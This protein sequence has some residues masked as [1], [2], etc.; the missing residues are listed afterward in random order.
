MNKFLA[1]LLLI[2]VILNLQAQVVRDKD[3]QGLV[4]AERAF[5]RYAKEKNTRDAFIAFLADD[6]VTAAQGQGP[7]VGKKYLEDQKPNE[8]YLHWELAFSDIASSG[9]FGFNTGPWEF[10]EKKTDEKAVA[11]GQFVSAWKKD[12]DG[13]WKVIIDI[14]ITHEEPKTPT[15]WTAS[16]VK[17]K[18]S[19]K[20]NCSNQ[21]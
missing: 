8:S 21:K 6:A 14:G 19:E 5:I 10:R 12:K 9:D 16:S 20:K 7:R 13:K 3:L 4:D 2:I 11:F 1:G 17:L 18:S 15:T